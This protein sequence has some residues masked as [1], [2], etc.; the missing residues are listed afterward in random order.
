MKL[1]DRT[2]KRDKLIHLLA[3]C[4]KINPKLVSS[5][6]E[7]LLVLG[8]TRGNTNSLDSPRLRLGGGH[9]LP[10]YS[11]LYVTPPHP[12]PN[13]FLSRDSQSG[14]SKLSRFGLSGL[15]DVI[16]LCS[17][18]RS[19]WG[20]KQSYNSLWELS[21]GVLHPPCTHRDWVDSRLLV[22]GSQTA[23]LIPDLSFDHNLCSRCPNGSCKA[24]FDIYTSRPFQRYDEH[25]KARC[26]D[27]CNRTL[28]FQESRKTPSSHFWE[29]EF[30]PHTCLKVG[31]W[32]LCSNSLAPQWVFGG[33]IAP[34]P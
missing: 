15:C 16:T 21:N 20:L 1:W 22:I 33:Q 24:I 3:T 18:L 11:I 9:H 4:N 30:H 13:G 6:L 29:C 14:V 34:N 26:F 7:T 10:P 19:G 2:R 27:F 12:R 25:F 5:P 28:K 32:Q 23:S 17:D 8:Q 31:L